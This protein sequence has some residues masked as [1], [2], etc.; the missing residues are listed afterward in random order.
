MFM[1]G[2][3]SCFNYYFFLQVEIS[4]WMFY[5]FKVIGFSAI[6]SGMPQSSL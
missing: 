6:N 4:T 3:V 5:V 1:H 2:F